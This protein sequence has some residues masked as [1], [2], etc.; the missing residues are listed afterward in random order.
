MKL[1]DNDLRNAYKKPELHAY[2]FCI[3]ICYDCFSNPVTDFIEEHIVDP[4]KDNVIDPIVDK[5]K[6]LVNDTTE[7]AKKLGSNVTDATET[8]ATLT[9]AL[10]GKITEPVAGFIEDRGND[11]GNFLQK[12]GELTGLAPII[13][14][15]GERTGIKSRAQDFHNGFL[16]GAG[17]LP[18]E[19]QV[20]QTANEEQEGDG[21]GEQTKAQTDEAQTEAAGAG[22]SAEREAANSAREA[23]V[24]SSRSGMMSG[25]NNQAAGLLNGLYQT[26]AAQ[27]AATQEDYINKMAGADVMDTKAGNMAR[28]GRIMPWAS[29]MQGFGE[30]A[31]LGSTMML[32]PSDENVKEAADGIDNNKLNESIAQFKSLYKRLQELKEKR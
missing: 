16:Y 24:N 11:V 30:G 22:A 26:A 17:L 31:K 8:A 20:Y 14:E 18:E 9:G 32:M 19:Q 10:A 25:V 12:T 6:E 4:V 2:H 5:G 13:N 15:I 7:T 27:N 29:G 1:W 21:K 28:G 23:G 3:D